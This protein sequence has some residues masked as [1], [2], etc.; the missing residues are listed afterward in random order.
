M[1]QP[2]E[3]RLSCPRGKPLVIGLIV[4]QASRLLVC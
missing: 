3:R 4:V 1:K 2:A